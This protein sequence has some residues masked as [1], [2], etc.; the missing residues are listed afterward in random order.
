M[1]LST[2]LGSGHSL[3]CYLW[4]MKQMDSIFE[5]QLKWNEKIGS[6]FSFALVQ[7]MGR[8]SQDVGKAFE[9]PA[10]KIPLKVQVRPHFF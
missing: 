9:I 2:C 4:L 5:L 1:A 10:F 6:Y 3:L 7:T 8:G